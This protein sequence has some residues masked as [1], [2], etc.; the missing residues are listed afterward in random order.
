[1]T[2]AAPEILIALKKAKAL[3]EALADAEVNHGGL[4]GTYHLRLSNE[5]RLALSRI[6]IEEQK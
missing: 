2:Q 4:I 3:T 1:M 6:K 5:L